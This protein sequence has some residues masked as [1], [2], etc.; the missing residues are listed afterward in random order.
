MTTTAALQETQQKMK[1]PG[2]RVNNAVQ[3]DANRPIPFEYGGDTF[4]A[5]E[6]H[7][8]IPFFAPNDNFFKVLL[9]ARLLSVTNDACISTKRDYTLGEGWYITNLPEKQ[10]V[11]A[12][13]EAWAKTINNKA[14]SLNKLVAKCAGN[15]YTFGNIFIE[16]VRGSAGGKKFVKA[17]VHSPLEC[18]LGKPNS[19]DIPEYVLKSKRF[20]EN[21]IWFGSTESAIKI[22]IYNP[23]F[24]EKCWL[25]DGNVER[26]MLHIKNE[27]EGYEY[28]GMPSNVASLPQ[29]V[30]EYEMVRYN[31]D[32]LENNMN[33][34][35]LVVLAGNVSQEEANKLGKAIIKQHTGK[36]KRGRWIVTASE[37]GI[38]G[39]KI[40]Q[41]NTQKEGSFIEADKRTQEKIILANQWDALLAGLTDSGTMGKGNAYIL[42][43]FRLKY[44]TAIQPVQ[45]VLIDEFINRLVAIADAWQ[46]T[47]WGAYEFGLQTNTPLSILDSE[48]TIDT[49]TVNEVRE[50]AGLQPFPEN[51]PRGKVLIGELKKGKQN[52]QAESTEKKGTDN[53]R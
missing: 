37:A 50:E 17:Y 9:E 1:K 20:K 24:P 53:D 42:N 11:D 25:K 3:L 36:G 46:G 6:G 21:G 38:D 40:E 15:W 18:R 33:P 23:L 44:K 31:L 47:K 34:G 10:K 35:G 41:F 12:A 45:K 8:Y 32:D 26:T 43:L 28:Y 14:E 51:D 16:V 49:W 30:Q 2:A 27:Y 22:P 13:L 39:S 29:Q 7:G 48:T 52:V 4:N 5:V 19:E